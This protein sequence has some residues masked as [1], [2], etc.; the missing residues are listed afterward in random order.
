MQNKLLND[1]ELELKL[2][3]SPADRV[4]QEYMESRIEQVVFTAM[5]EVSRADDCTTICT[6]YLDNGYTVRGESACVNP[7]N[8]NSEIGERIAYD[9]AINA[10]WPL[11]GFLLAESQYQKT[12]KVENTGRRKADLSLP[13]DAA[14]GKWHVEETLYPESRGYIVHDFESKED[15]QEFINKTKD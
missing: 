2:R 1:N 7:E 14:D 9:N 13:Y 8:Y 11:F 5:K 4:T 10:L 15:A 3:T 6:I 12:P